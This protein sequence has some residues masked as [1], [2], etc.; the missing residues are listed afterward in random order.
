VGWVYA[1]N[2]TLTGALHIVESPPT[3]T[4][5]ATATFDPTLLAAFQSEPTA[6]RLPTFTPPP[7]LVRPTFTEAVRPRG[8]FPTGA[9]ILVAALLGGLV[10]A[11]SFVSRR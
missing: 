2:V 5:L 11:V 9:V 3:L 4:P 8:D 6:T 10:L 7:P 1:A